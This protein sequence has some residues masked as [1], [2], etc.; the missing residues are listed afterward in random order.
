MSDK[1]AS[2]ATAL[3]I[4]QLST[5]LYSKLAD[6]T[7][8]LIVSSFSITTILAM[9]LA[10]AEGSTATQIEECLGVKSAYLMVGFDAIMETMKELLLGYRVSFRIE[11]KVFFYKRVIPKFKE[12]MEQYFWAEVLEPEHDKPDDDVSTEF[13][14]VNGDEGITVISS[15]TSAVV[16]KL[17]KI[18]SV[19]SFHGEFRSSSSMKA[20]RKFKV[21]DG[22]TKMVTFLICRGHYS[23]LW[24]KKLNAKALRIPYKGQMVDMVFVLPSNNDTFENFE[25]N[26]PTVEFGKIEFDD[27]IL[28]TVQI[29][30]F[31][32]RHGLQ[33]ESKLKEMGTTDMFSAEDADFSGVSSS[34]NT[35][36]SRVQQIVSMETVESISI[37]SSPSASSYHYSEHSDDWQREKDPELV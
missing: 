37:D 26:L 31:R 10:G 19:I 11:N 4:N 6:S 25:K 34:G 8:N 35:Y 29:P 17:M 28:T 36:V 7:E 15:N 16:H 14:D 18:K 9:L 23:T 12:L 24:L 20:S 27:E 21:H 22:L 30:C 3:A 1:S 32:S 33:L 13:F 5:N 2:E